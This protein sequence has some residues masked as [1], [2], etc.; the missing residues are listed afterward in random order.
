MRQHKGQHDDEY[1]SHA[2]EGENLPQRKPFTCWLP[3][4]IGYLNAHPHHEYDGQNTNHAET[5]APADQ[6][7]NK[8]PAGTPS[9]N[10]NGVPTIAIAIARPF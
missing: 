10:A 9:D 8:V 1:R 5:H 7:A 4:K 6:I 2:C 3:G